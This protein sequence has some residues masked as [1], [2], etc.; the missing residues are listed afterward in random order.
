VIEILI[1]DRNPSFPCVDTNTR[2]LI[3]MNVAA[4]TAPEHMLDDCSSSSDQSHSREQETD[5][6]VD[7]GVVDQLLVEDRLDQSRYARR[8][9]EVRANHLIRQVELIEAVSKDSKHRREQYHKGAN[10]KDID[11]KLP[12]QLVAISQSSTCTTVSSRSDLTLPSVSPNSHDWL[13]DSMESDTWRDETALSHVQ[14]HRRNPLPHRETSL[15]DDLSSNDEASHPLGPTNHRDRQFQNRIQ[16]LEAENRRIREAVSACSTAARQVQANSDLKVTQLELELAHLQEQLS[17][18]KAINAKVVVLNQSLRKQLNEAAAG[19]LQKKHG[20]LEDKHKFVNFMQLHQRELTVEKHLNGLIVTR[21][22]AVKESTAL[23]RMLL[24]TC[25]ECRQRLPF[26]RGRVVTIK[27]ENRIEPSIESSSSGETILTSNPTV[28]SRPT[29]QSSARRIVKDNKLATKEALAPAPPVTVTPPSSKNVK[30][31]LKNSSSATHVIPEYEQS[32]PN[33]AA[34]NLTENGYAVPSL[35]HS[36]ELSSSKGRN[37]IGLRSSMPVIGSNS[38]VDL[39]RS[40]RNSS[41]RSNKQTPDRTELSS[42]TKVSQEQPIDSREDKCQN[43]W[44]TLSDGRAAKPKGTAVTP[45]SQE[46]V[47]SSILIPKTPEENLAVK[48]RSGRFFGLKRRSD[49]QVV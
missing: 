12:P 9:V 43:E 48:S 44:S 11:T 8:K 30:S 16:E 7:N 5:E 25:Y 35:P 40:R 10:N 15:A 42:N 26:R 46:S 4:A 36:H 34:I 27:D 17:E 29:Y 23:K 32:S 22:Q 31:C 38:K 33:S 45:S 13:F 28:S 49:K 14:L 3:N 2:T 19:I 6:A 20:S 41:I 24:E 37:Q 47:S 39:P 18:E 1:L 21:N